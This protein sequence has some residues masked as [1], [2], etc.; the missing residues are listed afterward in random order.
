MVSAWRCHRQA[1]TAR[2]E[3]SSN[4]WNKD[5]GDI[6]VN[7]NPPAGQCQIVSIRN[8]LIVSGLMGAAFVS[9]S[10]CA[11]SPAH[12]IV[13]ALLVLNGQNPLNMEF[14]QMGWFKT[15]FKPF[16]ELSVGTAAQAGSTPSSRGW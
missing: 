6:N 5:L 11:L 9:F 2:V 3:Y 10:C 16:L 8:D 4:N 1:L 14:G 13:C 7:F 15:T 12:G